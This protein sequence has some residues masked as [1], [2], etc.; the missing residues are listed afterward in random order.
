MVHFS[1]NLFI[2]K[3][4]PYLYFYTC[5]CIKVYFHHAFH[6]RLA[7]SLPQ[8]AEHVYLYVTE[9]IFLRRFMNIC[10]RHIKYVKG[11]IACYF[12]STLT[13]LHV[14]LTGWCN[15]FL[16]V[17]KKMKLFIWFRLHYSL[18][19]MWYTCNYEFISDILVWR[20][21]TIKLFL[22]RYIQKLW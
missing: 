13:S 17:V 15:C 21:L 22:L 18:L 8:W 16:I 1:I 14:L 5:L 11:W 3:I 9:T 10:G 7:Y 6:F 19:R 2:Q 4:S 12:S 20:L